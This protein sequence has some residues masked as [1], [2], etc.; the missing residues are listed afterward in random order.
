MEGAGGGADTGPSGGGAGTGGVM[1]GT[2]A[3][4]VRTLPAAPIWAPH[5]AT[6]TPRVRSKDVRR[7]SPRTR[8]RSGL[9]PARAKARWLRPWSRTRGTTRRSPRAWRSALSTTRRSPS[10]PSPARGPTGPARPSA[11]GPCFVE[12]QCPGRA[13]GDPW[14]RSW[15]PLSRRRTLARHVPYALARARRA[16][17]PR[18]ALRRAPP[19]LRHA[20]PRRA[21]AGARARR[22]AAQRRDDRRHRAGRPRRPGEL[23]AALAGLGRGA[24]DLHEGALRRGVRAEYGRR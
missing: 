18:A 9:F 6:P 15:R 10:T 4:S 19:P 23:R 7:M 22:A 20:R 12:P 1:R 17:H 5:P 3:A 24:T 16:P 13:S 2:G 21:G 14:P 11:T 8:T